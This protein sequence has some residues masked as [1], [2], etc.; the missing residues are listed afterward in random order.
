MHYA[1]HQH[2]AAELIMQRAGAEKE[3]MGLTTW[4]YATLS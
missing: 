4:E 1:V 3:Y 2:T